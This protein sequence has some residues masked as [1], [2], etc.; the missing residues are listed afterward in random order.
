LR[1]SSIFCA[2]PARPPDMRTGPGVRLRPD[3]STN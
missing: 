3:Y 1:R 2:G